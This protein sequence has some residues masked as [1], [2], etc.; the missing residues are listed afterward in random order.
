MP[1]PA[2]AQREHIHT[3]TLVIN[4]YRRSD[5]LMDVE[6]QITDIKPFRHQMMD[7]FIEAGEPV[8]V[9]SI[10]ITLDDSLAVRDAV[11]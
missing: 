9:L 8:H 4:A 1:L 10:R 6:G 11:A 5:G 3:R 7:G 2:T